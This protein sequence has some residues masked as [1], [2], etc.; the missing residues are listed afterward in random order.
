MRL[1]KM[2]YTSTASWPEDM[3]SGGLQEICRKSQYYNALHEISGIVTFHR[4]R[5][6]QVLEGPED[7]LRKLMQRIIADPRHHSVAVISDGPITQRR[8]GGLAMAFCDPKAFVS[9]QLSDVLEQTA[10]ITRAMKATWH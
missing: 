5:L 4:G 1:W 6:A 3:A 7:A 2:S 8:H 10:E 9:D